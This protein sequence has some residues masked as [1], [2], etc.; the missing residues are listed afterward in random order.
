MMFEGW[1]CDLPKRR[2]DQRKTTKKDT[3]ITKERRK[4]TVDLVNIG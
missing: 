4:F 3:V 1:E 2:L